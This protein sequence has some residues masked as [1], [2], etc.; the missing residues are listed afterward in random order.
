MSREALRT[1]LD[2]LRWESDRVKAENAR[3]RGEKPEQAAIADAL[4]EID[5]Y[6]QEN[7]RLADQ[8][9][10]LQERLDRKG[11]HDP[12]RDLPS[13]VRCNVCRVSVSERVR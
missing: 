11:S 3:L 5:E 12:A 6:R 2:Q 4:A 9:R 8:L 13:I 10:A 1:Q 7:S